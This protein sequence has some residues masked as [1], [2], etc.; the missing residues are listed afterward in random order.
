M[1]E[2]LHVCTLQA[3]PAHTPWFGEWVDATVTFN[4]SDSDDAVP[5]EA[6]GVAPVG[7]WSGIYLD[8]ILL[9]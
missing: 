8:P 1:V 9:R 5:I 3:L 4:A 2:V 6:A 7:D